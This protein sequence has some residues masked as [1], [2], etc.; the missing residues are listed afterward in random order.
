MVALS[1]ERLYE[2]IEQLGPSGEADE[3]GVILDVP[4]RRTFRYLFSYGIPSKAA[5]L[6]I[7]DF[8]GGQPICEVGAGRGLWAKLLTAAGVAVDATDHAVTPEG[9]SRKKSGYFDE[10]RH[11]FHP[12][13]TAF[14]RQAAAAVTALYAFRGDRLVYVG[15]TRGG[16]TA[17]DSFFDRLASD[18]TLDRE[19]PIPTW[20]GIGDRVQL[21]RRR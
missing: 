14:A 17:D 20:D 21:Y 5:I 15:T 16:C 1:I 12:V 11:L 2:V 8:A 3:L 6:G 19:L 18:W 13:R 10:S 9:L 7:G 4:Q